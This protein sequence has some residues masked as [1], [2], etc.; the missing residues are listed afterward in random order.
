MDCR[1]ADIAPGEQI[2]IARVDASAVHTWD[3]AS[4]S[5]WMRRPAYYA[6]VQLSAAKPSVPGSSSLMSTLRAGSGQSL[7]NTFGARVAASLLNAAS[8]GCVR[9]SPA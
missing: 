3:W 9:P 1:K 8:I 2:P 4:I 7:S 6:F 5:L